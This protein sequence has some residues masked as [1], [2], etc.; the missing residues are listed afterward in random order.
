[1]THEDGFSRRAFL[2]GIAAV[3]GASPAVRA[4]IRPPDSKTL[5]EPAR[6]VPVAGECEVLVAGG[7]PAGI[8]AA[9]GAARQGAKVIL[10]ESKGTVGGIWTNGLLGCLLGFQDDFVD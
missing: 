7:G 10:I 2:G 1:M 4:D 3:C 6:D 5:R 9:V 8:A